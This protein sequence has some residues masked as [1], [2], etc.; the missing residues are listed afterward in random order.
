MGMFIR[1]EAGLKLHVITYGACTCLY[2]RKS[3]CFP[4]LALFLLRHMYHSVDYKILLPTQDILLEYKHKLFILQIRQVVER[5][6]THVLLSL[7]L[8]GGSHL[9]PI[10]PSCLRSLLL[11]GLLSLGRGEQTRVDDDGALTH[12]HAALAVRTVEEGEVQADED[13]KNDNDAVENEV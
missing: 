7:L 2:A 8:P 4:T 10:I 1:V 9:M 5:S 6:C 12:S 3:F 13:D 11:L